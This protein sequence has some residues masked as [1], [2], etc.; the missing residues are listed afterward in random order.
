MNGFQI[1]GMV[2]IISLDRL[3]ETIPT[4]DIGLA[5]EQTDFG[6]SGDESRCR[7]TNRGREG[8][9]RGVE[10]R[11]IIEEVKLVEEVESVTAEEATSD[12]L[13][14]DSGLYKAQDKR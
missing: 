11:N 5:A 2:V 9:A 13:E 8:G 1:W 4:E 12:I 6:R 3:P 10:T 7:D 14:E